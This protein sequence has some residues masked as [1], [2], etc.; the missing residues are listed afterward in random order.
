M[1]YLTG[2][3]TSTNF[4]LFDPTQQVFGGGNEG[5]GQFNSDAFYTEIDSAGD[6]PV[7]STYIGGSGDEDILNGFIAV[8][9]TGGST[10][11]NVYVVGDT[12]ST[13]LPIQVSTGVGAL[14]DSSLN[15]G[16]GIQQQCP[17]LNEQQQQVYNV[18][19]PDA[20][21]YLFTP[22]TSG[23]LVSLVGAGTGTVTSSPSGITCPGIGTCGASFITGTQVTLTA[24]ATNGSVFTDWEGLNSPCTGS[25]ACAPILGSNQFVT[26]RF[27]PPATPQ[28]NVTLAGAGT[29]T[30]NPSGITCPG[31]CFADF[32]ESTTVV[33]SATAASNSLFAGWSGGYTSSPCSGTGTCSQTLT[34]NDSVTATF[35]PK[36][37]VTLAGSGTGSVTSNLSGIPGRI[38][39]PAACQAGFNL[40]ATVVLTPTPAAGSTFAGWS[41]GSCSG[42]GTCSQTLNAGET[43]TATF[44]LVPTFDLAA[45][46]LTPPSVTPGGSATSSL[47]VTS[48]GAFNSS[49]SFSCAITPVVTPAPTC[50]AG[51]VTPGA[52]GKATTTLT[53]STTGPMSELAP[54]GHHARPLYAL[55][56]PIGGVMFFGVGFGSTLSRKKKLLGLLFICLIVSGLVFSVACGNGNKSTAGGSTGGTPAGTYA[57]QVTGT[58]GSTKVAANQLTLIV[59]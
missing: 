20:F 55:L 35:I 32:P 34:V 28:L 39:C 31:S 49:V 59:Q 18:T 21:V 25:G 2:Q 57:I 52:G 16:Q 44:N 27:T 46:A 40:G 56:L 1:I 38:D 53:V 23:L 3:T 51:A 12:N 30:S 47:T 22:N 9:N 36:L 11:G 5:Q 50:N 15:D 7:L 10:Q 54:F 37:S 29:V 14:L 8:D 41:G 58:S 26:A 45:S 19:C 48:I 6:P 17:V 43:V 42:T 24:T 4:P 33:L 13:N